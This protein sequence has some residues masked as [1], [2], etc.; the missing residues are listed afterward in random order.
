MDNKETDED[1][2]GEVAMM[3]KMVK[4]FFNKR[5][6]GLSLLLHQGTSRTTH[7]TTSKRKVTLPRHA[8]KPKVEAHEKKALISSYAWGDEDEDDAGFTR[9]LKGCVLWKSLMMLSPTR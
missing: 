3:T 9:D 4:R 2:D 1:E 8:Q 6:K 7:A 5:L